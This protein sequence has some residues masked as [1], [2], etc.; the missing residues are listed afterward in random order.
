M[1]ALMLA[2]REAY[3]YGREGIVSSIRRE[4][5]SIVAGWHGGVVLDN[6]PRRME[7]VRTASGQ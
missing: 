1:S 7:G 6:E 3:E 5:V 2:G 4:T